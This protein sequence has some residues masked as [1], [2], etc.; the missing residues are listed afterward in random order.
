M[1]MMLLADIIYIILQNH[2]YGGDELIKMLSYGAWLYLAEK[3]QSSQLPLTEVREQAAYLLC[4]GN[5]P[6]PSDA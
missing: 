2:S 6:S 3:Q 1:A 5:I 4:N